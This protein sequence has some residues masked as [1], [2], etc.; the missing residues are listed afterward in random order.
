MT[1]RDVAASRSA[2][3][4]PVAADYAVVVADPTLES[5]AAGSHSAVAVDRP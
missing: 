4:K 3:L 5:A 1:S 2:A